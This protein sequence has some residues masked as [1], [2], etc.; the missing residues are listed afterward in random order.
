MISVESDERFVH[1]IPLQRHFLPLYRENY[2]VSAEVI[3]AVIGV[4]EI[5]KA[6]IMTIVAAAIVIN[7]SAV[8]MSQALRRNVRRCTILVHVAHYPLIL[9]R[10]EG[11]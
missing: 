6:K 3:M 10:C 9:M 2:S 1:I 8:V 7:I 11:P 5:V 4:V